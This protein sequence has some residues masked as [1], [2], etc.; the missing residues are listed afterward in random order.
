MFFLS[1]FTSCKNAKNF[2]PLVTDSLEML[3]GECLFLKC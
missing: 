1:F 3:S 2:S